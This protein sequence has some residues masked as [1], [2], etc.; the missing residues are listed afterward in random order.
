MAPTLNPGTG[1]PPKAVMCPVFESFQDMQAPS[2]HLHLDPEE[3]LFAQDHFIPQNPFTAGA[4]ML[5]VRQCITAL[6]LSVVHPC[7]YTAQLVNVYQHH[8]KTF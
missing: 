2:D 4:R 5:K 1:L 8:V 3:T 6:S 7:Q